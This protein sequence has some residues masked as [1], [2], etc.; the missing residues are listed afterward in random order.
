MKLTLEG[1]ARTQLR[2]KRRRQHHVAAAR[3]QVLQGVNKITVIYDLL[4]E[5]PNICSL[6]WYSSANLPFGLE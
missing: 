5:D 1:W 2:L 6:H 4:I 3:S